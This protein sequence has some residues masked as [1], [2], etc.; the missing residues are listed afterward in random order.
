MNIKKTAISQ[1]PNIGTLSNIPTV[2]ATEFATWGFVP[3]VSTV[4]MKSSIFDSDQEF[5]FCKAVTDNP[6]QPSS[7]YPKLAGI[8]S[9][10]AKKVRQQLIS[11][12]LIKE[13]TLDTGG[14]GRSSIL[15]EALPA[16]IE[17]IK[18]YQGGQ[19]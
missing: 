16:G 14:R 1:K 13:H 17:A 3:E 12:G 11:K 8:S 5:S 6:M 2:P 7:T 15:L 4:A 10:T 19:A 9:K 18:E